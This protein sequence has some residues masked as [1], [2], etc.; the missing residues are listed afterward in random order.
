MAKEGSLDHNFIPFKLE[1]NNFDLLQR[2]MR[3]ASSK[4]GFIKFEVWPP[5]YKG[6]TYKAFYVDDLKQFLK[7]EN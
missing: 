3:L 1:S 5:Q 2:E 6:D 7:Q 4:R